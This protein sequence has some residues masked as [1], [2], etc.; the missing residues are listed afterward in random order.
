MVMRVSSSKSE[1]PS[2]D[3]LAK[4]A[5][6]EGGLLAHDVGAG[7][8]VVARAHDELRR[9]GDQF[10]IAVDD[11]TLRVE[12]DRGIDVETVPGQNDDVERRAGGNHPVE[13][14]Q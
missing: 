7:E 2:M 3:D 11:H 4:V 9:R 5:Q 10:Q 13:L 14:R 8:I 6:P 12:R 1:S